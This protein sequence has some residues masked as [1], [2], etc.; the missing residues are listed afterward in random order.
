M[1]PDLSN[2]PERDGT[3]LEFNLRGGAGC[4]SVTANVA[5]K[6]LFRISRSFVS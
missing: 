6:T 4:I 2:Y 5:P 3:A 1:G